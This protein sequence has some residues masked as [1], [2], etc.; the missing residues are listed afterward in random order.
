[1]DEL[2]KW[3]KATLISSAVIGARGQGGSGAGLLQRE[4]GRGRGALGKKRFAR[5]LSIATRRA[6][7]DPL[8]QHRGL[9]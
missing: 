3:D 6:E 5:A 2:E 7:T 4:T 8:A 9:M 1:M